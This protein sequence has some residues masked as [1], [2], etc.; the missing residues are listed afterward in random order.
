M[1]NPFTD[2]ADYA[3]YRPD[4]PGAL[5]PLLAELPDRRDTALDVG[6]GTGQ[7]TV[8]LAPHFGQVTG[9]DA[10]PSQ[11]AAATPGDNIT[12]RVGRAEDLPVEDHSIDLVTVAQ[13]AHW[14]DLDAFYR[15]ADRIASP[16]GAVA[17][18]SYGLCHFPDDPALDELYQE[19]YWGDFH[20]FWDP[21]RAHVENGLADL[22]FPY[23]EVPVDCPPIVRK[24]RLA[25]FLGYLGTWSAAKKAR[26]T[27]HGDELADFAL[28]LTARWGDPESARTVVWPMTVRAGRVG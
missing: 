12:Y 21:A 27:G 6:C 11:I 1:V 3:V 22:P 5:A 7:L 19:F 4:Y 10:S 15:E 23:E 18:V 28:R 24:H 16:G 20:R 26:E 9:V 17:L 25:H 13:A 2:G 14:F 8:Q